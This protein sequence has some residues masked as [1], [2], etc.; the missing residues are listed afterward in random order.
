MLSKE[1]LEKIKDANLR[2][3]VKKAADGKTLTKAEL[4]Q[5]DAAAKVQ[6]EPLKV[7]DLAKRLGVSRKTFYQLRKEEDGPKSNLLSEWESFLE[8]RAMTTRDGKSDAHLS[9]E[10]Q[11]IKR[12]LLTAQAGKEEAVRKLKELQLQREKDGLVPMSEAREAISK[13]L[14]PIRK[15]LDSLPRAAAISANPADPIHAEEVIREELD[16]VYKIISNHED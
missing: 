11:T 4:A 14:Q 16:K 10:L 12:R 15:L 9:E 7:T 5:L 6:E 1:Q 3:L 13:T 2:N 8:E